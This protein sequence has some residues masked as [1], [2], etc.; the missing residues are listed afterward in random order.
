MN[1]QI[2]PVEKMVSHTE[3]TTFE[4]V[5]GQKQCLADLD[6]AD[7]SHIPFAAL[8]SRERE[9]EPLNTSNHRGTKSNI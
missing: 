5:A 1:S 8:A 6:I 9:D 4:A 7:R 2:Q 3:T